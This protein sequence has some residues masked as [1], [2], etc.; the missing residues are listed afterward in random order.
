[1]SKGKNKQGRNAKKKAQLTLKEKRKQKKAKKHLYNKVAAWLMSSRL[2]VS[3]TVKKNAQNMMRFFVNCLG[4]VASAK[5]L[6][7]KNIT[8]WQ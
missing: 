4:R 2:Q 3:P 1:M 6:A 7:I 5:C 8:F